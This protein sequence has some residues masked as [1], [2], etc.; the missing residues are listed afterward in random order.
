MK[1]FISTIKNIGHKAAELRGALERVPPKVAEIREA[2][3]MTAGQLG[4]LR[5]DAHM[6]IED[7]KADSESHLIEALQEING[8]TEVF[9]QAGYELG[10]V[11]MEM[12]PGHRLTVHLNRVADV[13]A[14]RIH[15]LVTV[16][17]SRKVTQA[18]LK[19]LV[20]A[21]EMADKVDLTNL[22]YYKLLV[23]VGPIPCVR[24][25]WR[26]ADHHSTE[27]E[28]RPLGKAVEKTYHVQGASDPAKE[29]STESESLGGYG[30]SSFFERHDTVPVSVS[31][32]PHEAAPVPVA[33]SNLP[34]SSVDKA[35]PT[36]REPVQL[37]SGGSQWTSD[38]LDR[39][40]KMPN[41]SKYRR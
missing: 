4:Q 35:E 25:C 38:A 2:L 37:D 27:E 15:A 33:S 31:P 7:L 11:D 3:V 5:S 23:H 24:L 1:K 39:F 21:E 14:S 10:A 6:T 8:S 30:K 19:S 28:T 17:E 22:F 34:E 36:E 12:S 40:K 9:Q 32:P 16:N 26:S 20:Q 41:V 29:E 13:D 18:L